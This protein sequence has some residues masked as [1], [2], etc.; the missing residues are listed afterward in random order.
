MFGLE[1]FHRE[2][3]K[4]GMTPSNSARVWHLVVNLAT[5]QSYSPEQTLT[6]SL[7]GDQLQGVLR[8]ESFPGITE[9]DSHHIE[10]VLTD[11]IGY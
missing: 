11:L 7:T 1:D 5:G 4:Y 10:T 6:M 8:Y 3:S 2:A 9:D